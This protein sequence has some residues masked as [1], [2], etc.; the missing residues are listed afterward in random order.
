M[1]YRP[2]ESVQSNVGR[3]RRWEPFGDVVYGIAARLA[4]M[5]TK[6]LIRFVLDVDAFTTSNCGWGTYQI[7]PLVKALAAE[8]FQRRQRRAAKKTSARKKG[9]A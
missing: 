4:R 9:G 7:A 8:E 3:N 6:A 2:E 5:R 1:A